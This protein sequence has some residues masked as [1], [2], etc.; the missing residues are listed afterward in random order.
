V[1]MNLVN[2]CI[3]ACFFI[4]F[5]FNKKMQVF[6]VYVY[7]VFTKCMFNSSCGNC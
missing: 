4:F 3:M 1:I 6:D 7:C 2:V 5:I